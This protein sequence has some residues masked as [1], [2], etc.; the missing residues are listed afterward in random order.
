MKEKKKSLQEVIETFYNTFE[1]D[2]AGTSRHF[3]PPVLA[4]SI[5]SHEIPWVFF[6]LGKNHAIIKEIDVV[7]KAKIVE[8]VNM[9]K[10]SGTLGSSTNRRTIYFPSVVYK[11]G[12]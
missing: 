10:T 12:K 7:A 6:Q 4:F 9:D 1:F 5:E 8:N 3:N 11:R 2:G